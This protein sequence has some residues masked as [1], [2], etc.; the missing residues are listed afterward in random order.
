MPQYRGY[1]TAF[2]PARNFCK[3]CTPVPQYPE[4]LEV[5]EDFHTRTRNF[6]ELCRTFIPVPG[7]SVSSGRPVQQYPG[8]GYIVFYPPRTSV[9]SVRPSH[10]TRNFCELC[11]TSIPVP[12]TS[13]SSVRLP[14][15]DPDSTNPAEHNLVN[16][17]VLSHWIIRAKQVSN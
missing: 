10:N 5:L 13:G 17:H 2:I 1:G 15:P 4:R 3:F 9:S 7:T 16:I 8:Y 12:E 14:Y 6:C 11:N